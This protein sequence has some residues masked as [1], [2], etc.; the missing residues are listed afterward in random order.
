MRHP[1]IVAIFESGEHNGTPFLVMEHCDA[2]NLDQYLTSLSQR[3]HPRICASLVHQIAEGLSLTHKLGILHRDIKLRNV[4]LVRVSETAGPSS[5]SNHTFP[6]VPP[7]WRNIQPKLSDFGLAKWLDEEFDAQKTQS[8]FVAGTLQYMAPEQAAGKSNQVTPATD[9]HGLG[10]ILYEMLTGQSPFAGDTPVETSWNILNKEPIAVRTLRPAVPRDLETICH[11]ALEKEP[12]RRY[13]TALE[14]AEDLRRFLD[15]REILAKPVSKFER[16]FRWCRHHPELSGLLLVVCLSVT[17]ISM[18]GWWYSNRLAD[19]VE[20]ETKLRESESRLLEESERRELV[21]LQQ[22]EQ[23]TSAIQREQLMTYA[24]RMR[25][26]QDLYD[27]GEIVDYASLLSAM[28]PRSPQETDFRDFAWRLMIAKCGG[29][30][31]PFDGTHNND[32]NSVDVI[33]EKNRILAGTNHGVFHAWDL[34][35]GAALPPDIP[36]LAERVRI[37]GVVYQ[38][39]HDAWFY[40]HSPTSEQQQPK[41]SK[42]KY[43]RVSDGMTRT[44]AESQWFEK[45]SLSPDRSQFVLGITDEKDRKFQVYSVATG[46]HLWTAQGGKR[47]I[48]QLPGWGP[49]G[50]LAVPMLSQITVYDSHGLPVA[51]LTRDTKDDLP[52]IRSVAYSADGTLIA[53]LRTD[54][55][56]DLWRLSAEKTFVFDTTIRVS[57]ASPKETQERDGHWRGIQFLH[58]NRWLAFCGAGNRVYLWNLKTQSLDNQSPVFQSPIASIT[59]LP[60]DTLLLHESNAGLYRWNPIADGPVLAGHAREAWAVDYTPDGRF[61]ASGSD[62]GTMKIWEVATGRELATSINHAQTVVQT[63]FSP[64]GTRVASLCMDGSMRVWEFNSTTGQPVGEPRQV[65]EHR[66]GRSLCWSSDSRLIATGGNDGEVLIW[67]ANTLQVIRRFQDHDATVRQILFLDGDRTLLTVSNGTTVCIRDLTQ[68]DRVIH[69]WA[70]EFDTY[71]VALLPDGDTL[72]VGQA[73]GVISLRSR[74]TGKLIG[75]LTGHRYGVFSMALSP[76]GKVLASGD[77]GGWVRLWRTENHQPLLALHAGESKVNS[78]AFPPLGDAIALATHDGKVTFWRAPY[79]Q[80]IHPSTGEST[81]VRS[82]VGETLDEVRVTKSKPNPTPDTALDVS[83]TALDIS[84]GSAA[85]GKFTI[86]LGDGQEQCRSLLIQSD[87]KMI[88]GGASQNASNQDFA[89]ARL[90]INGTFDTTFGEGG[91]VTTPIGSETDILYGLTQLRSGKIVAVGYRDAGGTSDIAVARYH[92]DGTL[93]PT[94]GVEGVVIS[95]VSTRND[96]AFNAVEQKDGKLLV[97]GYATG[98]GTKDFALFRYNTDGTLDN[99]FDRDGIVITP[100]G[101]GIDIGQCLAL[102]PDGKIVVGGHAHNGQNYDFALAR[103]H[104]N[105]SLDTSFDGDG[106][107]TTPIGPGDELAFSLVIQEDG[108]IIVGGEASDGSRS[109]LALARYH[110]NGSLD[111]SFDRDGKLS[112]PIG[113]GDDAAHSVKLLDDGR[114]LVAGTAEFGGNSDFAVVRL[115][116]DGTLDTTFDGDG[117]KIQAIGALNDYGLDIVVGHDGKFVVAGTSDRGGNTDFAI[118]RFNTDG[119]L[120]SSFDHDGP[121]RVLTSFVFNDEGFQVIQVDG[122]ILVAGVTSF[123]IHADFALARYHGDGTLDTTFDRDGKVMTAIGQTTDCATCLTAQSDG[124]IIA[125]GYSTIG[126][127]YDFSLV[128]YHGDG[129][130]DT[131]FGDDGK[132]TTNVGD[133]KNTRNED[134]AYGVALQQDGKIVVAGY[135][136][137]GNNYDFALARYHTDGS[138]DTTFDGDGKVTTDF[139]SGNDVATDIVIQDDGKILVTGGVDV[140]GNA[141]FAVACYN[142]DGSLDTTF[143]GDGKAITPV[144]GARDDANCMVVQPDGKIVVAG[145]ADNV[146]NTD[147]VLVRY[148]RD[149][150]LDTTFDRDGILTTDFGASNDTAR[151]IAIQGDGKIV[152]AGYS[153]LGPKV[154]VAIARYHNDGTLDDTFDGDGRMTSAFGLTRDFVKGVTVQSDGMVVVTGYSYNGSVCDLA[155]ARY[156]LSGTALS[157]ASSHSNVFEIDRSGLGSGQ[158]IQRPNNT[159]DGL[160]R[161][162]VAGID[163]AMPPGESGTTTDNGQ[164][165]VTSTVNLAG[166]DTRREVTVPNTGAHDFART[167]DV[168]TNP[169]TRPITATVKLMGNL[170]SDAATTVFDTSD[171]DQSVETSDRWVGTDDD[172]GAGTPAIIHYIHGAVGLSPT[173]VHLVND[174]ISWTYLLTVQPGATVRL[175]HLTVLAKTRAEAVAAANALI[176]PTEFGGQSTAFLA[177]D[178]IES[179]VNMKFNQ[180]PTDIMLSANSID[181]NSANG[182]VVGTLTAGDPNIQW[183]QFTYSLVDNADGRF[184]ILDDQLIVADG[185]RLDRKNSKSHQIVVRVT[186]SGGLTYDEP[187]TIDMK[188]EIEPPADAP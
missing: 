120:D 46:G 60:D 36:L 180:A 51:K 91:R 45:L 141:E 88:V 138:L 82:G 179:Q 80:D 4:L 169:T 152:I 3:Q 101:E 92:T 85:A 119:T 67:D 26:A 170:G 18:G 74:S 123:G 63:R 153:Q 19:I 65:D 23:L 62:D 177:P 35:S 125:A 146:G 39:E 71:S 75:T 105:G 163:F 167:I 54:L 173:D 70:E 168:F 116:A 57:E 108:K 155:L 14:M 176:S 109:D 122:K 162:Q 100:L 10:V 61:L 89:L 102:Q 72:A 165:L 99:T 34:K 16:A 11:K 147:V 29:E 161:L 59:P 183:E 171:G 55:S 178:E 160:N 78:L 186:D 5:E 129:A 172:D 156:D 134:V 96:A 127:H 113:D 79:I 49:A 166:L 86:S 47:H 68:G 48:N 27:H 95:A 149:G 32:F 8:G 185:A 150:S 107:V 25:Q 56:V 130:L 117:K 103:Y 13:P 114:I 137:N 98:D 53:G 121:G 20:S 111:T 73:R 90:H 77:E 148:H 118:A 42:L 136:H 175:G 1:A 139:G 132:V 104:P 52:H 22:T 43:R 7:E 174:C 182:A 158:L 135:S 181:E 15:D 142:P 112:L 110:A 38:P 154:Q 143:D 93:D 9:V 97:A 87:G 66:K 17:L 31:R 21:L 145:V 24:S 159:L 2:G 69:K 140:A 76:D 115:H 28:R 126:G 83:T 81:F 84:F 50:G 12:S 187:F 133:A 184:A 144:G 64:S 124:K 131:T 40:A 37:C 41:S 157:V 128:R 188:E 151:S 6:V 58:G 94:F 30:I 106:K 44:V 33:L 164:T